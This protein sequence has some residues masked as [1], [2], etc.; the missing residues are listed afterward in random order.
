[1]ISVGKILIH[2]AIKNACAAV[3]D[4]V[5]ADVAI[6]NSDCG[7]GVAVNIVEG[8]VFHNKAVHIISRLRAV[9][10][11]AAVNLVKTAIGDFDI[12]VCRAVI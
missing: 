6:Y 10:A 9:R 1:M 2:R 12:F 3:V 11:Y 5:V 7:N 4:F 8:V